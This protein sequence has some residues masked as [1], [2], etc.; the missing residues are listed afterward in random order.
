VTLLAAITLLLLA[1]R[2]RYTT[3]LLDRKEP[4]NA[5]VQT[6]YT[7]FCTLTRRLGDLSRHHRTLYDVLGASPAEAADQIEVLFLYRLDGVSS[8]A[9]EEKGCETRILLSSARMVLADRALR[10][11]YD[12][13]LAEIEV[14]GRE[15]SEEGDT[16]MGTT[17]AT[18]MWEKGLRRVCGI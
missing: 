8:C 4:S 7:Y 2:L 16:R 17:G 11:G 12:A 3:H 1:L 15:A 6:R 14:M 5:V 9:D 18:G 10:D 13:F